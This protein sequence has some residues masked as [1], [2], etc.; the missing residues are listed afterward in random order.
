MYVIHENYDNSQ[1]VYNDQSRLKRLMVKSRYRIPT[2]EFRSQNRENSH[3]EHKKY[4]Q[5]EN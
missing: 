2:R 5:E 3:E 1:H 4:T